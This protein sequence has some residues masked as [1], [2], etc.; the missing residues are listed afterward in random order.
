MRQVLARRVEIRDAAV[1]DDRQIGPRHLETVD[2]PIVERGH[3]P[4]L[5]RR[6]PLQPRL[7]RVHDERAA[8]D[9]R[10]LLDEPLQ[11]GFFVLR[12]DADAALH[13]DR[14]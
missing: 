8:P 6:K 14:H 4:V 5:L 1:Q 12:V 11:I 9:C 3:V 10:N 2:A 13:R 7:A